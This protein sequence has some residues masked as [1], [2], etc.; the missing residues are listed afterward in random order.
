MWGTR[1]RQ[2]LRLAPLYLAIQA[3]ETLGAAWPRPSTINR[4]P[5]RRHENTPDRAPWRPGLAIVIPDRD[6]AEMLVEALSSV[7]SALERIDEP[8]QVI[9]VANGAPESKY[10]GVRA[11]FPAVEFVHSAEPLGFGAAIARGLA[12]VRHDWVYLMNND[13]TLDRDALFEVAAQRDSAAFS[14]TSQIFQR[15]ADGRREETGF[16]DW[17][18]DR[19]GIHVFHAPIGDNDRIRSHL[20]GSGGATLFRTS[21]LSRYVAQSRCYDPFYWE[22]I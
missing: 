15:S 13:M 22:D 7:S 2:R 10:A 17:Y 12:H 21:P 11:S 14:V 4:S 9:V 3:A 8:H 18:I 16:T 5:T 20:A 1:W 19:D 6:A